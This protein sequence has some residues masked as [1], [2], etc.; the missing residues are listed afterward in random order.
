LTL[1]V[2]VTVPDGL[3]P[4]EVTAAVAECLKKHLPRGWKVGE[5]ATA[6]DDE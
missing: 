3:A 2:E 6:A 1:T 4:E 5:V